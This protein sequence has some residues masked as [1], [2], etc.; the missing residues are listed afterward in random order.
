M[1]CGNCLRDNALVA[2]LRGLGHQVLMVPLYLPLTLDETDQSAG[3]PVFFSGINVYLDQKSALFRRAPRWMHHLL[4]APSLLKWAAQRSARTQADSLGP[5]TLSMLK[6]E[7]GNQAPELADLIT[8]LKSQ[9]PPDVIVLSNALL[10]GMARQLKRE[11]K[12]P[13]VCMLQGEDY[14]LDSLPEPDRRACWATLK[15]RSA[16]ADLFIAPSRYFAELMQSRLGLTP[17]RV[18]VIYNGINLEGY[19]TQGS[20][21]SASGLVPSQSFAPVVGYLARMC[22][23]KGLDTLVEAF[24]ELRRRGSVRGLKLCVVGSLGPADQDFVN[25]QRSRLDAAGLSC[26]VTFHPNVDRPTKLELLHSFSVFSVPALYGEAFGLYVIESLAAGVPVVQPRTAAFPELVDLTAG[27]VLCEPA[28]PKAL[29]DALEALLLNPAQARALGA[30]GQSV[31]LQ[32]MSAEAM[33]RNVIEV[34]ASVAATP[35]LAA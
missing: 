1:Y 11:L 25:A 18:R 34:Y 15:E 20:P 10:L 23:E 8:W 26:E 22:R 7:S 2:A 19:R 17:D 21:A 30:Q 28:N 27:G 33:A 29:A 13:L 32:Q 16:D 12:R 35:Q 3:T 4:A 5:L 14:F 24:V 6:G 9:P 31:V